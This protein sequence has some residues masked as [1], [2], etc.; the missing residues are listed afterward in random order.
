MKI[1]A[2]G[3][4]PDGKNPLRE[5]NPALSLSDRANAG[6][7]ASITQIPRS[8]LQS[9]IDQNVSRESTPLETI[10]DP[11]DSQRFLFLQWQC[12]KV[13][14]VPHLEQEGKLYMPP[15]TE[16]GAL[17]E[18]CLP[19]RI[20]PCANLPKLLADL[21]ST[22]SRFVDLA[23]EEV[24]LVSLY[25]LSSWFPDCV[26][27]VPYLWLV[28]PLG[29][30][31]STLLK[32]LHCVCRRALLI[33]DVRAASLYKLSSVLYP[34]LLLDELE[35][36]NSRLGAEVRRLLRIG[37][38]PGVPAARNGRLFQTFS[39][40]V[41]SSRQ[42][43]LDGALASRAI[44]IRMLPTQKNLLPLDKSNMEQIARAFQ[45]KL[46]M[47]RLQN[48]ASVKKSQV[49]FE[50]LKDLTPRMRD[51]VQ[52]MAAPLLGQAMLEDKLISIL[53]EYDREARIDRSLE[54]EWLV[55][56][57]L[58]DMCHQGAANNRIISETLV[59]G[60]AIHI[61]QSL[62]LRGEDISLTSRSV[63]GVLKGL[64]IRTR[65]L[66][67]LGRGLTFTS[68]MKKKTHELARRFGFD[69]TDFATVPGLESGYGG[70]PCVLCEDFGLTGGLRFIDLP[71]RSPKVA[72]RSAASASQ[73]DHG[74]RP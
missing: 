43:P 56:E 30:G 12:G 65:R 14:I 21:S 17:P 15:E 70:A 26:K 6:H 55:V 44:L 2:K 50:R 9:A 13:T 24:F 34:T 3:C 40:K 37:N 28:G 71:A 74:G 10:R 32:F 25:I 36:D 8:L 58:F 57:A 61:N 62:A 27:S 45:P 48:Y 67:N 29:S 63:G 38:M 52:G 5:S 19:D 46:L 4:F 22:I 51:L 42:P 33:G 39:S 18:L 31:K 68:L 69:R 59:G 23:E 1:N 60:M 11:R 47:F 49:A 73:S 16:L 20:L 54:P 66:G 64:G 7:P 53:R 41:I 72:Q 35:P